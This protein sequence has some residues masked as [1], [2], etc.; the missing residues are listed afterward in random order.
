MM[1]MMM[2]RTWHLVNTYYWQL[3]DPHKYSH[4]THQTI[5][6]IYASAEE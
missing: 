3:F 6:L 4:T 1:M 2:Q 5:I